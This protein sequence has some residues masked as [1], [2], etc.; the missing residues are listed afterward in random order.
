MFVLALPSL[1]P[2]IAK[3]LAE[4]EGKEAGFPCTTTPLPALLFACALL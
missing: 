4:A 3:F 1:A 2:S